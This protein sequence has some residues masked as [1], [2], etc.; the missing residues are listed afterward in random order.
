L[1]TSACDDRA[2]GVGSL[3][4]RESMRRV[5]MAELPIACT[6]SPDALRARRARLLDDLLRRAERRDDLPNGVR[7]SFAAAGETLAALAE[8]VNAERHCCRFL[9]FAILVEPD[10]GPI[11]LELTGPPGTREFLAALF[12]A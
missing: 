9:R 12:E 10:G 6:L 5:V 1:F 7:L 2:L 4:R 8:A 3:I 11:V